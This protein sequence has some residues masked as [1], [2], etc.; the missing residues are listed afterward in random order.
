MFSVLMTPH[1]RFHFESAQRL[2]PTDRYKKCAPEVVSMQSAQTVLREAETVLVVVHRHADLDSV[3]SAIGLAETL[4]ATVTIAVPSSV[5]PDAGALLE[6]G[7][8][9]DG[10]DADPEAY[11]LTVV[12]D[13]PSS[14]KVQPV[15]VLDTET[16]LLLVDHH[17]PDNLRDAAE[18][19]VVDTD[20]D[21]T[22]VIVTQLLDDFQPISGL[23]ATALAAGILDD[24]GGLSIASP[25]SVDTVVDLLARAGDE[26]SL[27][28]DLFNREVSFDQ[29]V[30]AAKA[31][32]RTDGYKAGQT[33]L[34]ITR[35]G[36]HE[37][38]AANALLGSGAD[39]AL[40][41]SAR[42]TETRVVGRTD[43]RETAD[44]HLPDDVLKPLA[45]AFGGDGGG[46][47]GAG[48]AKLDT[49]D[50]EAVEAACLE[51]VEEAFGM[52]FG[53]ME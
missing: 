36:S 47:A 27:L 41:I 29:R 44:I 51:Q 11:D 37:G 40:V 50:L 30:A 23:G 35:V 38:A 48:A 6:R 25:E 21:A 3:G 22:A 4:P 2:L 43:D 24:T 15:D 34:F 39:I 53:K 13:T 1:R 32:A 14:D 5:E 12:V 46:H 33:L 10:D 49:D 17:D 18:A 52:T 31:V 9:V 7:E 16:R 42:E 8:T 28:A 26:A 45:S 19:A 20:A